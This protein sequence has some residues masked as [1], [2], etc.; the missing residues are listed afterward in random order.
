M[1]NSDSTK[2]RGANEASINWL[3]IRWSYALVVTLFSVL[4]HSY[5]GSMF[6]SS[7]ALIS[8]LSL[9]TG[10]IYLWMAIVSQQGESL[11]EKLTA[12]ALFGSVFS[13]CM[14]FFVHVLWG[15]SVAIW[16]IYVVPAV[17]LLVAAFFC[18]NK[19]GEN[20]A[21][22]SLGDGDDSINHVL[23]PGDTD[24]LNDED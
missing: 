18:C 22:D 15:V 8:A 4:A 19:S 10:S 20:S 9:A 13:A 17:I 11:A 14:H 2:N 6:W 12:T 1:K 21:Q 5:W 23:P 16:Y 3:P 7:V 24:P